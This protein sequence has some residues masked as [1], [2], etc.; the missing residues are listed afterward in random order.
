M[1]GTE[2]NPQ[3][4]QS[5]I[6]AVP[7]P[8]DMQF[9]YIIENMKPKFAQISKHS[10]FQTGIAYAMFEMARD[11]IVGIVSGFTHGKIIL[12]GGIQINMAKPCEDY[13]ETLFF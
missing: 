3:F 7:G 10:N 12:C 5:K 8:L 1:P 2:Q 13:F 11:F 9:R 6:D 4:D